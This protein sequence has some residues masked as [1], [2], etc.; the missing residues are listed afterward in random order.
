M[1]IWE[2]EEAIWK[3]E[4]IRIFVRAHAETKVTPYPYRKAADSGWRLS[5]LAEKRIEACLGPHGFQYVDGQGAIP[6]R[7]SRLPTIRESYRKK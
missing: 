5:E 4:G 7:G 3:I 6:H 1:K 2:F